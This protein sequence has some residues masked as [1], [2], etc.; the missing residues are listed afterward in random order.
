MAASLRAW[1]AL[2]SLSTVA[3]PANQAHIS[4]CALYRSSA[5]RLYGRG[6]HTLAWLLP[7]EVLLS[8]DSG[9][10]SHHAH[11][12]SLYIQVQVSAEV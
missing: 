2:V 9:F 11:M 12:A 5:V 6:S 3:Q 7:G 8:Q 4:H 10:A 1:V